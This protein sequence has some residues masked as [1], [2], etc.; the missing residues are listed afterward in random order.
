MNLVQSILV[1]GAALVAILVGLV[2]F[3]K[4]I[5]KRFVV[6]VKEVVTSEI[7]RVKKQLSVEFSGNGGGAREAINELHVKVDTGFTELLARVNKLEAERVTRQE[8]EES[9]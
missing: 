4:F 5:T 1:S 8:H 3:T 2:T 6:S 7:D 9:P